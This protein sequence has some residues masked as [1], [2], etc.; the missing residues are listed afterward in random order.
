M[1]KAAQSPDSAMITKCLDPIAML[2]LLER[3][4]RA[5]VFKQTENTTGELVGLST[6]CFWFVNVLASKIPYP[7]LP[8]T[9]SHHSI[10][11]RAQ[12][13][14]LVIKQNT[15]F[16]SKEMRV[17]YGGKYAWLWIQVAPNFIFQCRNGFMKNYSY[18]TIESLNGNIKWTKSVCLCSRPQMPSDTGLK[19]WVGGE[20]V[21]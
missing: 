1:G 19:F 10:N 11:P 15:A 16:A 21:V 7:L 3:Q 12:E 20:W 17:Y 8:E 18:R 9:Y 4:L 6:N 14:A 13:R 2:F 5:L